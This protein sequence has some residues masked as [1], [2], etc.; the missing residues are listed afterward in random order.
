MAKEKFKSKEKYRKLGKI[1]NK[2]PLRS[3]S[4]TDGNKNILN[5][6]Y[7]DTLP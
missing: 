3:Q 5:I 2:V 1:D 6:P 7:R 4:S